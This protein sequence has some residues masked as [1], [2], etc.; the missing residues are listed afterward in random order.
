MKKRILG[1]LLISAVAAPAFALDPCAAVLCLSQR[2][3]AP[4]ECRD[5]V[6]DYFKIRV[7]RERHSRTYFDPGA[8][9]AK[10]YKKVMDKCPDAEQ[11][12]KDNISAMYGSLE[13]SPFTFYKD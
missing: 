4:H 10:R 12:D 1:A 2:K 11:R 9:A 3:T 6:K 13:Y 5:E 8:T 7:Y